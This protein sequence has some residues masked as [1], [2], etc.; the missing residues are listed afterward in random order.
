MGTENAAG[1]AGTTPPVG[2]TT[3]NVTA[4]APSAPAAGEEFK[5]MS[6]EQFN[7]RMKAEREAGAK[8]AAGGVLKFLGIE[9]LEDAKARIAKAADLEKAALSET[10][11]RD[12][13]IKE[14]SA[15]ALRADELDALVVAHAKV[16]F[17]GIKSEAMKKFV[18]AQAGDDPAARLK[19]ITA[20][21]E[22][23]LFAE[24]AKPAAE[25]KA[26]KVAEKPANSKA[27]GTPPVP[28]NGTP[29]KRPKDMTKAEFAAFERERAARKSAQ[30]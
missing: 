7:S 15:K 16:Q 6:L 29:Q 17:D 18:V 5:G 22:S 8:E 9:K 26:E 21:T 19:A 30:K 10:E 20:A 12:L 24:L 11:K 3:T 4:P 27:E 28:A 25:T 2:G 1:A 23:G 14:L 13:Q